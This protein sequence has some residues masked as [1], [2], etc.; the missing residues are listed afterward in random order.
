MSVCSNVHITRKYYIFDD[1]FNVPFGVSPYKYDGELVR[2]MKSPTNCF[3]IS[4]S[5]CRVFFFETV[6]VK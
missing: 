6:K 5:P 4:L 2:S 1:V 3:S